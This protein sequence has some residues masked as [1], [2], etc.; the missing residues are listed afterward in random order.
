M[1]RPPACNLKSGPDGKLKSNLEWPKRFDFVFY[2][3]SMHIFSQSILDICLFNLVPF[4]LL[5]Q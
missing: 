3:L 5:M 1:D 4:D 2:G